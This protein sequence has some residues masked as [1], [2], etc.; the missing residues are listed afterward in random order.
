MPIGY[1]GAKQDPKSNTE[2]GSITPSNKSSQTPQ[3]AAQNVPQGQGET[4]GKGVISG[5]GSRARVVRNG[6]IPSAYKRR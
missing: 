3:A 1:P 2:T 6:S 5:A 4:A